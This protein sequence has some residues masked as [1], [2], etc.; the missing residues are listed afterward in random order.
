MQSSTDVP[1]DPP[2]KPQAA[3]REALVQDRPTLGAM[4]MAK[5]G[6]GMVDSAAADFVSSSVALAVVTALDGVPFLPAFPVAPVVLL[7]VYGAARRL[8]QPVGAGRRERQRLAGDPLPGRRRLRLD[9]FPADP[10][11]QRRAAGP[12]DR[13]HR[14]RQRLPLPPHPLHRAHEPAGALGPGRRRGSR[15]T[16]ARLRA[17]EELRERRRHRAADREGPRHRRPRRRAR[18]RRALPRRPRRHLQPARRRRRPAG[19]RPRLQVDR[20]SGQ[21]AAP[22]PRPARGPV[23]GAAPGRRRAADRGRGARRP[24]RHPLQG[25]RSPRHPHDQSQRRRPGDERGEEHRLTSSP[26]CPRACTR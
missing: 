15:R 9:R 1:F 21:P 2:F 14:P 25:P 23:R 16:A 6:P 22:P 3:T 17:A 26:N 18:G 10:A 20:R 8:R 19:T 4:P 24:R 5:S 12:V 11:R 13:L 7:V